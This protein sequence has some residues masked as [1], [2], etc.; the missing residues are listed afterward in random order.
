M[1]MRTCVSVH[2]RARMPFQ[3][4]QVIALLVRLSTLLFWIPSYPCGIHAC[5]QERVCECEH[6]RRAHAAANM[7][8][9]IRTRAPMLA[10]ALAMFV[11]TVDSLQVN[12]CGACKGGGAGRTENERCFHPIV[13]FGGRGFTEICWLPLHQDVREGLGV[14][15]IVVR[16]VVVGWGGLC[17][18]DGQ[19]RGVVK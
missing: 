14:P 3:P 11:H 6:V 10:P 19:N 13:S 2:L 7:C 16:N 9:Q 5:V 18:P 4:A 12:G 8:I 15:A 17:S 1:H